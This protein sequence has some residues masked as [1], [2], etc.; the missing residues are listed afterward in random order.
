MAGHV[1]F[2][3]ER[4]ERTRR[5]RNFIL[6]TI[7]RYRSPDCATL[8]PGLRLA[9]LGCIPSNLQIERRGILTRDSNRSPLVSQTMKK[10]SIKG[11]GISSR[12]FIQR[13]NFCHADESKAI[14]SETV[15]DAP[16]AVC[17]FCRNQDPVT[18][19]SCAALCLT[20]CRKPCLMKGKLKARARRTT[21][22][23]TIA[24]LSCRPY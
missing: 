7:R 8:W 3:S 2:L 5:A 24:P 14:K 22:F 19:G 23:S 12:L 18:A 6:E 21:L 15:K 9:V 13:S 16:T 11:L 17:I 1:F 20:V 10:T 4:N